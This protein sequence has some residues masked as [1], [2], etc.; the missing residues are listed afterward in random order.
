MRDASDGLGGVDVR[1]SWLGLGLIALA[2]DGTAL[3]QQVNDRVFYDAAATV[4]AVEAYTQRCAQQPAGMSPGDSATIAQWRTSQGVDLILARIAQLDSGTPP[5]AKL[6]QAHSAVRLLLKVPLVSPC[7]AARRLV[8][9][10]K[11]QFATRAPELLAS[12]RG[13]GTDTTPRAS[14]PTAFESPATSGALPPAATPSVDSTTSAD[15]DRLMS[16]IEGFGFD[17]GMTMGVG[18]FLTTR[19]YPVVLFKDGRALTDAEGLKDPRGVGRHQREHPDDWT[20]WRRNGSAIEI[21]ESQGWET[22]AFPTVYPT[23]PDDF[24]LD[25]FFRSLSGVGTV[26]V[27]GTDMVT[28]WS[29]YRFFRD[30]RIWRGSGAGAQSVAGDVSTVTTARAPNLRGR[31]R[32]SRLEVVITWDDGSIE[33]RILIADPADPRTAIWLDG[34]G[35]ARR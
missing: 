26:G 5:D 15:R 28:A 34:V 13:G 14:A 2:S 29:E 22:L 19:I 30:G 6:A 4:L 8:T 12:L 33:R 9:H 32:V 1:F 21:A 11:A 10:E 20:R 17:T 7:T 35:Y 27:G 25:G 16:E 23:L 18:G 31:Y 3:A 24:R